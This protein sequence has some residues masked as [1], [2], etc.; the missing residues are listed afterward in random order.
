M[1]R[2]IHAHSASSLYALYL[3]FD[4]VLIQMHELVIFTLLCETAGSISYNPSKGSQTD[5]HF[6]HHLNV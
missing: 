3:P 4:L 2:G 5:N 6:K 1:A